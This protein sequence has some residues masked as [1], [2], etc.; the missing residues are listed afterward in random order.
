MLPDTRPPQWAFFLVPARDFTVLQTWDTVGMRGTGSNTIVTDDVFVPA[1]RM[2]RISDLREGKGPGGALHE[3]T[4]YRAPWISY[5]PGTFV[6]PMLGA[7]FGALER[8]R[9][10]TAAR[11]TGQGASVAAFASVQT[12]FARAAADLDAAELLL[13][14]ALDS[15]QGLPRPTLEVRARNYRDFGRASELI[16]GTVDMLMVMSGSAGFSESNDIQRVWRDIHLASSHV[17]LNPEQSFA[18]WG[19]TH[20]GLERDPAQQMY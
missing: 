3:A 13:T 18:H 19:R 4:Y 1:S 5:A 11:S 20:L 9:A 14:R 16:V 12:R 10:W 17:S 7:A 8:F 2:V 15:A 6:A